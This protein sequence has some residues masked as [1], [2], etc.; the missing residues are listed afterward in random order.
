MES[1]VT[2]PSF[3]INQSMV[4]RV[5]DLEYFDSAGIYGSSD[6]RHVLRDPIGF[7]R[8]ERQVGTTADII[9][10]QY[11]HAALLEPQKIPDRF[12]FYQRMDRRTKEGKE[13][14]RQ[15]KNRALGVPSD[16]PN[17]PDDLFWTRCIKWP[18]DSET[19]EVIQQ[20]ADN[21]RDTALA[22]K[23]HGE[24]VPGLH[25]QSEDQVLREFAVKWQ[26][27][28]T[29]VWLRA[30]FDCIGADP[31]AGIGILDLKKKHTPSSF[32]SAI[33]REGLHIQAALY[34]EAASRLFGVPRDEIDFVW[35]IASEK[36]A[37]DGRFMRPS[38]EM[39]ECGFRQV[40][41]ALKEIAS[42]EEGRDP[43][44]P[45]YQEIKTVELHPGLA[46]QSRHGW[47]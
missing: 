9:Q 44:P 26:D 34:V 38:R 16:S 28:A 20:S 1:S 46:S 14:W 2:I 33:G 22:L 25:N 23:D 11:L 19:A 3:T 45:S 8:G 18:I 42:Y 43:E 40:G 10:G 21:L 32:E 7:C 30:K 29:G 39:L 27:D 13:S 5:N 6:I 4:W 24:Y 35:G 15:V 37:H 47:W 17:M 12:C 31:L 41:Y 36:L